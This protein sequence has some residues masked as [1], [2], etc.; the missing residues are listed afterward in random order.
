MYASACRALLLACA[1]ALLSAQ[2]AHAAS[3]SGC[4]YVKWRVL[5]LT[6]CEPAWCRLVV[7]AD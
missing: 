7:V 4:S 3:V 2:P 1:L 6:R 5:R